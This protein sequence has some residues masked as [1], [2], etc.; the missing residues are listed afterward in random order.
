MVTSEEMGL[1]GSSYFAAY[2]TVP[3]ENIVAN[4][5][6]DMPTII[7]PLLAVVPLGAQH[8]TLF[9][10]VKKAA[11][12]LKLDIED[13]PEPEQN[14]FTRSDQYSF[15]EQGIPALH[16]KYGD[17]TAE[18][19]KKLSDQVKVWRPEFYHQPQDELE[20]G[21]FDFGAGKKYVQLCFLIS[22]VTAQENARPTWNKG[23][24]FDDR[25]GKH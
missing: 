23:D 16:I 3:K 11:G 24:F 7:A 21:I 20:S 10:S 8:S 13:D 9:N 17:K 5:N 25:F 1:L 15:V 6:M 12:Y 2:P 22:Y 14:R 19:G 18:P 4:V